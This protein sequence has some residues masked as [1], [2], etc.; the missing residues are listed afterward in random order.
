MNEICSSV[1]VV[2]KVFHEVMF[3][4]FHTEEQASPVRDVF[5]DSA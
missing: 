3:I 5:G 4:A 1:V 2:E